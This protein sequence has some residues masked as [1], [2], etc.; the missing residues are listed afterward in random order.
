MIATREQ[1]ETEI[2]QFLENIISLRKHY[3]LSKKRMAQIL[4]IGMG[5][6]NKIEQGIFPKRLT[7]DVIFNITK[8]LKIPPAALFRKL[9]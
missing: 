2:E 1:K 6:Y 9:P 7:T 5:N 4:G 3:G 8:Y